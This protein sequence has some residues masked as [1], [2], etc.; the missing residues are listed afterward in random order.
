[1]V[2]PRPAC[3]RHPDSTVWFDGTYG[4]PPHL[5]QRYKCRP[6]DGQP[7]HRFTEP[8]PRQQTSD[9]ECFECERHIAA[10]EGPPTPRRFDFAA[11][12]VASA[13]ITVGHGR[14]YRVAGY[15]VRDR[16]G[17]LRKD[18]KGFLRENK[19]GNTVAD[20]VEVFAPVIYE[21]YAL[22][23]WPEIVGLDSAPFKV[24]RIGPSGHP[25][26]GGQPAFHVFGAYGW[27][28]KKTKGSV[29]ALRAQPGF[30][31]NQG[32]PYWANFLEELCQ[33]FGGG[34]PRQ[35]VC[36]PDRDIW[37]AIELVW[38]PSQ[39]PSPV[40]IICHWHLRDRLQEILRQEGIKGL[41]PLYLAAGAALNFKAKWVAF[42]QLLDQSGIK[43]KTLSSWLKKWEQRIEFQLDNQKQFVVA[44]GPLEQ[45]LTFVRGS[46]N[47]RRGMF[48]NRERLNRLLMLMQLQLNQRAHEQRYAKIIREELVR[49]GGYSAPRRQILDPWKQ[50]SLRL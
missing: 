2:R 38:P 42:R 18:E 14:P 37:K 25:I 32:V 34:M 29:I 48:G 47:D 45:A 33:R 44:V 7:I 36:D 8:L 15:E 43:N 30:N 11:R 9:G 21:R 26:Q 41:D 10:H 50:P 19:D 12:E 23:A 1:M 40:V 49:Q 31:M 3:S 20:W 16:A 27:Q 35:I 46:F 5:R 17:R 22:T 28:Q 13:L 6:N 24:E 4:R 39:G